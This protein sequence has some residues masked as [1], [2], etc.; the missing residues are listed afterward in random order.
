MG[1][2]RGDF[3]DDEARTRVGVE[4]AESSISSPLYVGIVISS[5]SGGDGLT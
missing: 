4:C 3:G 5:G 1:L 2:L